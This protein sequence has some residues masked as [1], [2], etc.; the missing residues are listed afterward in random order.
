[1]REPLG[2]SLGDRLAYDREGVRMAALAQGATTVALH[3]LPHG[4]CVGSVTFELAGWRLG[5]SADGGLLAV[6]DGGQVE[7]RTAEGA[8]VQRCGELTNLDEA[9]QAYLQPSPR[10]SRDGRRMAARV[11]AGDWRIWELASGEEERAG[12]SLERVAEFAGPWPAEWT[13]ETSPVTVF[14]HVR[15]GARLALPVGGGWQANPA[16]PHVLVGPGMLVELRAAG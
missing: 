4:R 15:S 13:V 11:A 3:E 5:M 16:D 1:M 2:F 12:D 8:L 7:V 6:Q 14:T 10:F 9:T